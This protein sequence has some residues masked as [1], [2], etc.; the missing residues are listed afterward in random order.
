MQRTFLID[1]DGGSDA[2]VALIMALR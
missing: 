1:T 2:V